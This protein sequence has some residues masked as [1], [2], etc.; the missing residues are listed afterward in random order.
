VSPLLSDIFAELGGKPVARS[1]ASS[2]AKNSPR[3]Q[4]SG[5]VGGGLYFAGGIG[6]V[7]AAGSS[8]LA[9]DQYAAALSPREA[10]LEYVNNDDYMPLGSHSGSNVKQGVSSVYSQLSDLDE[11]I[12]SMKIGSGMK[13]KSK[14]KS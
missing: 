5:G 7:P 1:K 14:R 13:A 12:S 4:P 2:V 8:A 9:S 6:G 10:D 11:M 3:G